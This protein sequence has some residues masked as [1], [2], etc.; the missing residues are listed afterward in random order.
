[1]YFISLMLSPI[2][3]NVDNFYLHFKSKHFLRVFLSEDHNKYIE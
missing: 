1:M 2:I 3:Q